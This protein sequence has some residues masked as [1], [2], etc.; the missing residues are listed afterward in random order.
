MF[1]HA[2]HFDFMAFNLNNG[3]KCDDERVLRTLNED[4]LFIGNN[5]LMKQFMFIWS[6]FDNKKTYK[7][8]EHAFNVSGAILKM[9]C[10]W[11]PVTYSMNKDTMSRKKHI[12]QSSEN[13]DQDRYNA[14]S[15]TKNLRAK[16]EQCGNKIALDDD[17]NNKS[18]HYKGSKMN[19]ADM[20]SKKYEHLFFV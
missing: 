1:D 12:M 11:L 20:V 6:S 15:H 19:N 18:T 13:R 3:V 10:F 14:A 4:V 9:R 17:Y 5:T 8:L 7:S 16:I 2:T